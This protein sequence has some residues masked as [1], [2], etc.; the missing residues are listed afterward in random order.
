VDGRGTPYRSKAFHDYSYGR[1]ETGGALEDHVAALAQLASRHAWLDTSRVG[2][3]G[4]SGGG[5]MSA[6]AMFMY[7]DVYKVA[8]ASAGN[9]DQRGYLAIWGESY[10]G[11]PSGNNYEAQANQSLAANL[12][13]KLLLMTGDLDD[14]VHPMLTMW[15]ADALIKANKDFDLMIVPN[16]NHGSAGDL[17][18]QRRRW[19]YFVRNLMG[20]EPPKEY[21][22]K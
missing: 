2:I 19:D 16:S 20:A 11:M 9:H 17:Y 13:G 8:V 7:P 15:V 14:N 3:F 22:L 4:H 1:L 5:F 21:L 18:F 12:K 6:R 10:H